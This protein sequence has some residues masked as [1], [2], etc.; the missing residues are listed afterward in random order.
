MVI[1]Y[2]ILIW[3]EQIINILD[4]DNDAVDTTEDKLNEVTQ[5]T[6]ETTNELKNDAVAV[7][8]NDPEKVQ[9]TTNNLQGLLF[10]YYSFL[11]SFN[12]FFFQ[13]NLMT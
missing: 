2:Y 6:S 11:Y 5:A 10:I 13:N 12:K 8:D 4:K 9:E 7:A 1:I 3:K